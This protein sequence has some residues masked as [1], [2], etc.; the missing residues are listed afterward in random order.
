[1][2][3]ASHLRDK[4]ARAARRI[5]LTADGD[6][7]GWNGSTQKEGV[8]EASSGQEE[9]ADCGQ[10]VKADVAEELSHLEEARYA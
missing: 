5:Q 9:V 10:K 3:F 4:D 1:V 7:V 2:Q 6:G 8:A